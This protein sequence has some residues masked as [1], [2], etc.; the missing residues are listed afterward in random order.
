MDHAGTTV[1]QFTGQAAGFSSASSMN[2]AEAM[3]LLLD[4]PEPSRCRFRCRLRASYR[5]PMELEALL[6]RTATPDADAVRAI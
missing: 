4:P 5:L 2:D 1:D 3:R 6:A